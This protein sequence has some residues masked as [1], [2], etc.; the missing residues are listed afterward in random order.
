MDDPA[1]YISGSTKSNSFLS[2]LPAELPSH[3]IA[4]YVVQERNPPDN[5][6]DIIIERVQNLGNFIQL[7]QDE[8]GI[9]IDERPYVDEMVDRVRS[10]FQDNSH[11]DS[12]VVSITTALPLHKEKLKKRLLQRMSE[13]KKLSQ[14][15]KDRAV[16]DAI[17]V[18]PDLEVIKP[19]IENGASVHA[20]DILTRYTL[21]HYAVR[22]NDTALISFLLNLKAHIDAVNRLD[23]TPLHT[24][25][26]YG[27]YEA[28]SLL[29][30][31]NPQLN[32][33][34]WFKN[35]ALYYAVVNNDQKMVDLLL[36]HKACIYYYDCDVNEENNDIFEKNVL[37]IAAKKNNVLLIKSLIKGRKVASINNAHLEMMITAAL[38]VAAQSGHYE[39]IDFLLS[40]V[41]PIGPVTFDHTAIRPKILPDLILKDYSAIGHALLANHFWIAH[42]LLTFSKKHYSSVMPHCRASRRDSLRIAVQKLCELDFQEHHF[43]MKKKKLEDI[44]TLLLKE[45]T[46]PVSGLRPSAAFI[47]AKYGNKE[48]L[49]RLLEKALKKDMSAHNRL[50]FEAAC[51]GSATAMRSLLSFPVPATIT[52]I[53]GD[54]PLHKVVLIVDS[55]NNSIIDDLIAL[56]ADVAAKNRLKEETPLHRAIKHPIKT[57]QEMVIKK[58]IE[59]LKTQN[60]LNEINAQTKEGNTPLMAIC[61]THNC[62]ANIIQLLC[63][64]GAKVNKRNYSGQTALFIAANRNSLENVQALLDA[65]ADPNI[66]NNDGC[67]PLGKAARNGNFQM[68]Q[69][70]LNSGALLQKFQDAMLREAAKGGHLAII[71]WLLKNCGANINGKSTSYG[72]TPLHKAVQYRQHDTIQFLLEKGAHVHAKNYKNE[73][74]YDVAI[75]LP[76]QESAFVLQ[77]WLCK[78]TSYR[79]PQANS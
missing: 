11:F 15:E 46:D 50:M 79:L 35:N 29:L 38:I 17:K 5:R 78:K 18:C 53:H 31:A 42:K 19:M 74:P 77:P 65:K 1:L 62:S 63:A 26:Q 75:G 28:A 57:D 14:K 4:P 66:T 37:A 56:G 49:N 58:I 64:H 16:I 71:E 45:D 25:V 47:A 72:N 30:Q 22:E 68:I 44:I 32:L 36:H 21:L 59:H 60:R 52:D 73:T 39:V 10:H 33:W 23:S 24:A 20:Q 51:V 61:N 34:D 70:L 3:I 43:E 41:D 8:L 13:F 12:N 9:E 48:L 55:K 67:G 7:A 2:V 40:L 54:T 6:N 69:A 27:N 76:D